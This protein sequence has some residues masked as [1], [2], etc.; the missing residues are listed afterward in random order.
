ML[1]STT[2]RERATCDAGEYRD[3]LVQFVILV[4]IDSL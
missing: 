3:L 1:A 4:L 2:N